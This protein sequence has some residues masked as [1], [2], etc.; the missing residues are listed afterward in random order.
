VVFVATVDEEKGSQMGAAL[1]SR[2]RPELFR[3][4]IALS[5]GGG[6]PLNVGGQS[7]LT[8]TVG[9]KACC[10]VKL[11]AEGR[12]GH[13]GAPGDDQAVVKLSRALNAV[14]EGVNSLPIGGAA[15]DAIAAKIGETP[16]NALAADFLTYSGSAGVAM[17]PMKIGEK[18]N[19]LPAGASVELEIRPL[20]GV[21]RADVEK[22]L[23]TWLNGTGAAYEILWFQPGILC[24]PDG[25]L[26]QVVAA[27][28]EKAA[29]ARGFKAKVLPML[30]LGRTD[31]RFF[32]DESSVFGFSPLGPEDAFDRILPMVHGVDE[33]VSLSG[34]E[35]G[36]GVLTDLVTHLAT[37]VED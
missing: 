23:E 18:V 33:S 4:A 30:A 29:A 5:E 11:T 36:V 25:E 27:S 37:E 8:M 26:F 1:V 16:D 31:G 35:F 21:T 22:W 24:P 17:P 3:R 10:R 7:Y 12:P 20:P 19:V 6:F 34:F 13:A 15:R 9:E 28:A 2:E 14:L 32:G